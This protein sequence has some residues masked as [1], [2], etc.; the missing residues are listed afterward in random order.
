MPLL[1]GGATTS[2]THTAVKIE[3]AVPRRR[4]STSPTPRG[5]SASPA[6]LVDEDR[7]DGVRG[8]HPRG[9]R[10]PPARARRARGAASPGTPSPRR[11]ATAWPS[12]GPDVT[13]PRADLPRRPHDRRPPARGPR[14]RASTGRRSSRRGRSTAAIPAILT[15]P[16]S[17]RPP[18]RC[19]ADALALLDRIVAERPLAARGGRRVLAGQQRRRRHRAVH[20]RSASAARPARSTRSASR[21]SSRP[22]ARTW[23]S[24][25]SRRRARPGSSTTSAASRSRRAW[26]RRARGRA[27]RPPTTTTRRS[28]PAPSPTAWPRRSPSG[29]TSWSAASCGATRPTRRSTNDDL[30]AERYQGIRPAPGY[31]A[32]PDHTEKG[33][34]VPAARGRGT[35]R[36]SAHRVVRDVPGRGGQR[37]LLLAPAVGLLRARA[38]R[39]RP[40]RGLRPS[41]ADVRRRRWPAGWRPNLADD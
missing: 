23:P 41:Q 14:R 27:S 1:I 4:S 30:I 7:R 32:C 11:A 31:P 5:R 17:G 26:P 33:D 16:G 12:T 39:A 19:Y 21:W 10:D 3:P 8:G 25:T 18:R 6:A 37:L 9:V 40:A 24:P 35:R 20:R 13:P 38:D 36:R 15:D 22:V 28:S 34:A 29:S 2:R